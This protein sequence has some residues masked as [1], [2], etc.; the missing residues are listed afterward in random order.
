MLIHENGHVWLRRDSFTQDPIRV[1]KD[2]KQTD[3]RT[4]RYWEFRIGVKKSAKTSNYPN[5]TQLTT[6]PLC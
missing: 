1:R 4:F 3:L 2:D 6:T 5:G